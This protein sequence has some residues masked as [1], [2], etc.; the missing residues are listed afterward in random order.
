MRDTFKKCRSN[1]RKLQ[2]A[3]SA[4]L[5]LSAPLA[6][7]G[8]FEGWAGIWRGDGAIT[9]ANGAA[10]RLTCR[11]DVTQS[12]SDS[13]Q[14]RLRCASDTYRV[15]IDAAV[16]HAGGRVTGTWR[17][18]NSG[19]SGNLAGRLTGGRMDANVQ[20]SAFA[21]E[22]TMTSRGDQRAFVIRPGQTD[23]QEVQVQLRKAAR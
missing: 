12:D 17:D 18:T 6:A 21:A 2:L 5:A 22:I 23:V 14:Q 7:A 11:A 1:F 3:A 15:L 10:E 4:L 19:V 8:P 13:F 16:N 9:M 20:G